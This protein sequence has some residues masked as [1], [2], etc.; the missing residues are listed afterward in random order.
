MALSIK[1][2]TVDKNLRLLASM[3]GESLTRAAASA[4]EEKLAKL[5]AAKAKKRVAR[6]K[7]VEDFL[8]DR[9]RLKFKGGKTLKEI[10]DEL[11]GM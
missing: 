8:K 4:I 3:T 9:P 1:D 7:A 10:T 2:P 11:W 5:E 6:R